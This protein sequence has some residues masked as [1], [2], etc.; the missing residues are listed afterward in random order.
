MQARLPL[1]W[2]SELLNLSM[3]G[4]FRRKEWCRE[5]AL[6][7]V[8]CG[9]LT[10]CLYLVGPGTGDERWSWRWKRSS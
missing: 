6:E 7:L 10:A 4:L 9:K 3:F 8:Y 5:V 1:R 2:V